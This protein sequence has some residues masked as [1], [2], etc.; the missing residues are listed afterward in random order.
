MSDTKQL[1]TYKVEG[2]VVH[3]T[4]EQHHDRAMVRGLV[5]PPPNTPRPHD[6]T[7]RVGYLWVTNGDVASAVEWIKASA[8]RAVKVHA[9][10]A[11]IYPE[12]KQ[13]VGAYERG[14]DPVDDDRWTT[15]A[16][17]PA[18]HSLVCVYSRGNWRTGVVEKVAKTGTVTV[19]YV[20]ST[21]RLTRLAVKTTERLYVPA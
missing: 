14:Y 8:K 4:E 21:G 9:A 16:E 10:D 11:A 12:A 20:S 5:I 18:T 7:F 17:I 2:Y 1:D 13:H 3:V 6:S 19:V 15:P